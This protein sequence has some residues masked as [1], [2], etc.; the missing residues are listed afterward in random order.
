MRYIVSAISL[1][2]YLFAI[3]YIYLYNNIFVLLYKKFG[4]IRLTLLNNH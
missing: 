4:Y 1:I 3:S 2:F